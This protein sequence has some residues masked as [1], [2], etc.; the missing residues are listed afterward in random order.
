MS[1]LM[2]IFLGIVQGI[3]EFLPVSSS[4]HLAIF[5]NFFSM[6]NVESSHMFFDVLLHLGTLVSVCVV[7]RKEVGGMIVAVVHMFTRRNDTENDPFKSPMGRMALM[8]II[9]TIPL[10]FIIFVKDY[11]EQLMG[12]SLFIGVALLLTGSLL[13]VSDKLAVGKKTERNMRVGDAV[14]IGVTQAVATIPGLSRSGATI[15]AGLA[16]GLNRETA[17]NFSFMMSIPAVLG[18]NIVSLVSAISTGIEWSYMPVYLLGFVIAAVVGYF[19][20]RLVK[21]LVDKN[22]F[23]KFAY[24]CWAVGL[25][26]IIASFFI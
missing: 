23:G 16:T 25:I 10:V 2:S 17:V 20:I 1:I 15:T 9:A 18:A 5:Q 26:T 4:G 14:L 13:F 7:Y 22:K 19:A 24:Y 11:I 6:E 3:T 12:S 8:I 21:M